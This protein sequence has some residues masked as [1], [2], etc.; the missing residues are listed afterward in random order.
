MPSRINGCESWEALLLL[1]ARAKVRA[2]TAEHN[3]VDGAPAPDASLTF[4]TIYRV[5]KLKTALRPIVFAIVTQSGT[6]MI[7]RTV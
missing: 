6:T 2:A 5:V 7:D 4:S 3:L 1:T